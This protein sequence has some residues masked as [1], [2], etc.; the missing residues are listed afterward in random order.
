MKESDESLGGETR[1]SWYGRRRRWEGEIG[2]VVGWQS[3]SDGK[4]VS[5]HG[6]RRRWKGQI[7]IVVVRWDGKIKGKVR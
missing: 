5:W 1:Q 2:G 7:G 6:R 4:K 3:C